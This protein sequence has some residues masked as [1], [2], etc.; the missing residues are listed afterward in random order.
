LPAT[1]AGLPGG[2]AKTL[3]VLA[4]AGD[5]LFFDSAGYAVIGSNAGRDVYQKTGALY[6]LE[7]SPGVLQTPP[8]P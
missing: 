2:L 4:D 7:V 5:T 3:V 6:G 1:R 8:S